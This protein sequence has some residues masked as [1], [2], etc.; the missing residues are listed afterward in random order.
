MLKRPG[1][2]ALSAARHI[3]HRRH[4]VVTGVKRLG[5]AGIW[6]WHKIPMPLAFRAAVK[7]VLFLSAEHFIIHTSAYQSWV[8][9]RTGASRIHHF[10]GTKMHGDKTDTLPATVEAPGEGAWEGLQPHAGSD[11]PAIDVIVPVYRGYGETLNCLYTVL[12]A[13]VSTPFELVVINDCSP[14]EPLVARLRH[15]ADAGLFTLLENEENKGFVATVNRGMQLHS[16][17]DVVLLN[18]DT[19]VYPGWLDRLC[20]ATLHERAGTITP[21]SNNA[22]I[23]S[24]PAFV[25]D[26]AVPLEVSYP[27]LDALAAQVNEKTVCDLPTGVGFCMYITRACLDDAGLFDVAT[28]GKGYGE[29]NDFCCRAAAGGYRNLLAADVFV[30]HLGGVSFSKEKQK[31]V[32]R[33]LRALNRKHPHY[34]KMV[35]AF[36]DADPVKPYRQ[37]LDLARLARYRGQGNMLMVNHALG[38]GTGRHVQELT[39]ALAADGIGAY[40]L[41]PGLQGSGM[42]A[43][44]HIA[45]PDVPN[46][47]FS[48]ESDRASF[49]AALHALGI[50][51][52]HIHHVI[53]FEERILDFLEMVRS[54]MGIACDVTVH[55]YFTVCPRINLVDGSGYYC[56]E[57]EIKTCEACIRLNPSH[58]GGKPVWQWRLH[59]AQ[60]LGQ[61]RRV[62]VPDEDVAARMARYVPEAALVVRP[63]SE[64]FEEGE[65]PDVPARAEGERLRIAIIGAISDI[66]GSGVL[67]G[68]VRDACRRDLPVD[69]I[70]IGHTNHTELQAGMEHF[71]MTGQYREE[72][73]GDLL[74]HYRPHLVFIPSIWPET[75]CYTLSYAWRYGI[76]PVVFDIGAPASRIR[77]L[78]EGG[79][80]AILP[81]ALAHKPQALND[82][83]LALEIP[84]E[85]RIP[86]T[87]TYPNFLQSYYELTPAKDGRLHEA[88]PPRRK[89]A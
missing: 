3:W 88:A 30:R 54:E 87:V 65:T 20:A 10:L 27:E 66:K 77:T 35:S 18:S 22:E 34:R 28:F 55:D 63:H 72:E 19:E 15:L 7:D 57:P 16:G 73:M 24:Y 79:G 14:D 84:S 71:T 1:E 56:G 45:A 4:R 70:L 86:P 41:T 68:L 33:G 48:M 6:L 37:R 52:L 50:S 89:S 11:N 81:Y 36:L 17:R 13:S 25:K 44:T 82:A 85:R 40:L 39:E 49:T 32:A 53:G 75:Y 67:H 83:L 8:R 31:L 2:Y 51:H 64:P 21:F 74:A 26:N 69:Y 78:G 29:E 76:Y 23:C 61:A 58:A 9:Q 59:F 43:L 38:G 80:G 12:S 60:L 47:L 46:L 42:V 5:G 62:Y